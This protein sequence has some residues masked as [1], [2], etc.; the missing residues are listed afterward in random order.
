MDTSRSPGWRS[1]YSLLLLLFVYTMSFIDRQI[2]SILIQPI[3]TEFNVSDSAMGLLTGLAFALFY[4]GLAVPFGRYADRANRRNFI[5]YCCA[6]WSVM[7]ALCGMASGYWMLALARA[8]VAVG[9]AGGQSPSISVIADHYPPDKRARA[10]S[11]Y[12]LGP[13]LGIVFGLGLGGWIAQHYGWRSAFAWM[14]VP[15]VAAALLL[16]VS[17]VEPQRGRWDDSVDQPVGQPS[18]GAQAEPL[19]GIL[20]DLWASDAF[21]RIACAGLLLGFVGYGIGIWTPAFLVRSYGVTLQSAGAMIGILGGFAAI[22]G[23]L[24]GGWLCDLMAKRDP[25]WRMGV[26]MVGCLIAFFAGAAFYILP[27]GE[28]WHI[29]GLAVPGAMGFYM[30]FAF[31]SVWWTAPLYATLASLVSAHRRSTALA[32]FNLFF[33]LIGSGL[34]P[35]AVGV[36][37][38]LLTPRFGNEALRWALAASMTVFLLAIMAFMTAMKPYLKTQQCPERGTFVAA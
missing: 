18:P 22:T 1:H 33:T 36:L 5:A 31:S 3:K 24:T 20:R 7:T 28:S 6:V 11:V 2:M 29:A 15:G 37:S 14:S 35:L 12:M 25:R 4:S 16:R 10:M 38:D 8:G 21:T 9:E 17:A 26:P 13:Q 27:A 32:I 34:G 30:L 23:A 19:R